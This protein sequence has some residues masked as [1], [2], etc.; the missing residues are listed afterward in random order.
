MTKQF[1]SSQRGLENQSAGV[2]NELPER[3]DGDV[4]YGDKVGGDQFVDISVQESE[5][6]AI[7][8]GAQATVNRIFNLDI[9]LLPLVIGL[10]AAVAILGYF[11]VRTDV[12]QRMDSEFN[13]AIAQFAALDAQGNATKSSEGARFANW[14]YGRVNRGLSESLG[15]LFAGT[16]LVWPPEY[17]G[18]VSGATP[19]EREANAAALAEKIGA[20]VVVY[21]VLTPLGND[22]LTEIEFYVNHSSFREGADITGGHGLGDALPIGNPFNESLVSVENQPLSARAQGL[23]LIAVG[24][25]YYSVDNFEEAISY[26]TRADSDRGWMNLRSTGK[27]VLK[28]LLGNAYIRQASK[29]RST[30]Y[31]STAQDYYNQALAI[32]DQYA[33]AEA[34]LAGVLYLMA[35]GGSDAAATA[36]PIDVT[37]LE[38]SEEAFKRALTLRNAPGSA[39]VATKVQFGLGQIYLLRTALDGGDWLAQARAEFEAIVADFEAGNEQIVDMAAHAYAR[40]GLIKDTIDNDL[41]GALASYELASKHA[42]PFYQADYRARM[43]DLYAAACDVEQATIAFQEA[44]SLAL[45][46]SDEASFRSYSAKLDSLA[47]LDCP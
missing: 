5:A 10:V 7:G 6:V 13:V 25:A 46:R 2:P 17:T 26:F 28:L 14:L 35:L 39:N 1:N 24:L 32:D 4:V 37:L 34:G 31:L 40:L 20:D 41:T 15:E 19:A 22:Q 45:Q 33:R 16:Y 27:H 42:S 12:P 11:L 9:R 47:N 3:R 8:A 36:A 38:Q 44:R 43:G 30:S 18:T 29:E 21:G 23:S